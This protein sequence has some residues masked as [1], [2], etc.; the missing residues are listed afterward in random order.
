MHHGMRQYC[1]HLI[2]DWEG[3]NHP[4]SGGAKGAS[5]LGLFAKI[6]QLIGS[7]LKFGYFYD[8]C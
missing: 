6:G 4:R 5:L 8:F 2:W 7:F 3:A 1:N